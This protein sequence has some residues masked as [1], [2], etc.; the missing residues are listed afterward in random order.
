MKRNVLL[1]SA[2]LPAFLAATG[3]MAQVSST[4]VLNFHMDD[5]GQMWTANTYSELFVGQGAYPDTANGG[6]NIWNGFHMG[7]GFFAQSS[8][9]LFFSGNIGTTGD[10]PMQAGNPGNPYAAYTYS[11]S[12][13]S[14][15]VSC[16][17]SSLITTTGITS[18]KNAKSSKVGNANSAGAYGPGGQLAVDGVSDDK[19]LN[20]LYSTSYAVNGSPFFL[21]GGAAYNSDYEPAQETFTLGKIPVGTYGLFLY[22]AQFD[23]YGGDNFQVRT[24]ANTATNGINFS[25][26]NGITNTLNGPAWTHPTKYI[27][28]NNFVV[29]TNIQ[30]T[31]SGS[32]FIYATPNTNELGANGLGGGTDVQTITTNEVVTVNPA[33][34]AELITNFT[35]VTNDAFSAET[36]VNGLQ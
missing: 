18:T 3:A 9:N 6:N 33:N 36:D 27:L 15:W 26:L 17:G 5:N 34:L 25:A 16:T 4:N 10:F 31:T 28:G 35:Y 29:F 1:S 7:H 21:L 12:T 30:L 2:I 13:Y 32:I 14:G 19:G 22:G 11:G 24:N 8:Y 23:N 20:Y